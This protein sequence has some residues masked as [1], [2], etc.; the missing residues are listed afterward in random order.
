M[1]YAEIRKVA[2]KQR[3]YRVYFTDSQGVEHNARPG[4]F[5]TYEDAREYVQKAELVLL[6]HEM[7]EEDRRR[8]EAS[9]A[10]ELIESLMTGKKVERA[11]VCDR[12]GQPAGK[13]GWSKFVVNGE[14]KSVI[15]CQ[16]CMGAILG[17]FKTP[18]K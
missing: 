14:V 12:C 2:N 9:E 17:E 1:R 16:D 11:K 18:P 5:K 15:V 4:G 3:P 6:K 7:L 8:A 13:V 10:L